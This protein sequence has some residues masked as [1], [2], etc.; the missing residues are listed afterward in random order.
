MLYY[1]S[2][3]KKWVQAAHII[4]IYINAQNWEDLF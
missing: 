2:T 3:N 1:I 4:Y